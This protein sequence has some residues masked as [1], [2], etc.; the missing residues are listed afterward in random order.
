MATSE[1]KDKHS[2]GCSSNNGWM[3]RTI[4]PVRQL[5]IE[6]NTGLAAVDKRLSARLQNVKMRVEILPAT[7]GEKK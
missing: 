3:S 1:L 6:L 4:A 7:T 5:L 2:M